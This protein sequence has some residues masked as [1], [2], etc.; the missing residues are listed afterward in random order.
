MNTKISAAFNHIETSNY[1]GLWG[2]FQKLQEQDLVFL[3]SA[4]G[5][6][7]LCKLL[8]TFVRQSRPPQNPAI[9]TSQQSMMCTPKYVDPEIYVPATLSM[10]F[11]DHRFLTNDSRKILPQVHLILQNLKAKRAASP[12]AALNRDITHTLPTPTACLAPLSDSNYNEIA[13][14]LNVSAAAIKAVA[15]VES[16]GRSGFDN[17]SYP[18]ILFEAHHFR[19]YTKN[20]FDISH[21]HLSCGGS[22]AKRFYNWNQRSRLYEAMI[23]D[24]IAAIKACSWGKFQVLGSNHSGWNDPISFAKA[25]YESESNHLK[26]F[27]AYCEKRNLIP[28]LRNKNWASF[29]E[30]YNGKNYKDFEYDTKMATAYKT[31]GGK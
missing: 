29:A 22:G 9:S 31:N 3:A 20:L 10:A 26:S 17:E 7:H 1:T 18:K 16:G 8:Y 15:Q 19:K 12:Q 27:V 5:P 23:L 30:G 13:S 2:I 21:P 24:P 4:V 11:K 14:Q 28:H 6:T 25:M